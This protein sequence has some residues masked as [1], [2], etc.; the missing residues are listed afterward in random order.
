[1]IIFIET[2]LIFLF[3]QRVWSYFLHD[4]NKNDSL[5]RVK[6]KVKVEG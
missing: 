1:L 4:S 3:W 5:S 2:I 6:Q